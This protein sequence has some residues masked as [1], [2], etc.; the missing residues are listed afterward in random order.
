MDVRALWHHTD[1]LEVR[2]IRRIRT[3]GKEK[4]TSN[5][6]ILFAS[7]F[8]WL[9]HLIKAVDSS[10]MSAWILLKFFDSVIENKF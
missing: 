7:R 9:E 2:V 1:E 5:K 3:S 10:Q 6:I 4:Q 8:V